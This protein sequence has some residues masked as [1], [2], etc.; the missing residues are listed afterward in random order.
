M[1][2]ILKAMTLYIKFVYNSIEIDGLSVE[3]VFSN[4]IEIDDKTINEGGTL[5]P[6]D[7]TDIKEEIINVPEG[8][9][10]IAFGLKSAEWVIS[11]DMAMTPMSGVEL[12][13]VNLG[14]MDV[15]GQVNSNTPFE[16]GTLKIKFIGK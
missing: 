6:V 16:I 4:S 11:K 8:I 7:G 9:N 3:H 5:P 10:E 15:N 2:W 12:S 13:A 14:T 1:N